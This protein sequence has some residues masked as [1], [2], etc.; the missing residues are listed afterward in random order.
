MVNSSILEKYR[1]RIIHPISDENPVGE[2][3]IDDADVDFIE[4]E[5]MKLGALNPRDIEWEKAEASAILLLEMRSKDLKVLTYLLQCLQ[6]DNSPER[7]AISIYVMSDFI[8]HYWKS[9]Y[10]VQDDSNVKGVSIRLK[11]FAQMLNRTEKAMERLNHG[12][13]SLLEI[14]QLTQALTA[15]E[16]NAATQCLGV[17]K[18]IYIQAQFQRR[19]A[20]KAETLKIHAGKKKE[21]Q[22]AFSSRSTSSSSSIA[23][24]VSNEKSR[25]QFLLKVV[26]FLSDFNGGKVQ[27]VRLRR[28][29]IWFAITSAPEQNEKGE[30]DL[31]PVCLDRI[32][33]YKEMLNQ[34]PDRVLWDKIEESVTLAPF[35]IDGHFLSYQTAIKLAKEDCALAILE[36][37][38]RF[39]LRMPDLH[40]CRF[41]GGLPFISEQTRDWLRGE[42]NISQYDSGAESWSETRERILNASKTQGLP[43]VLAMINTQLQATSMPREKFYWRLFSAE[44]MGN[45]R[46]DAIASQQYQTLLSQAQNTTLIDWEPSLIKR[47]KH[48][49]DAD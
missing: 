34:S 23:I 13:L 29:A 32:S 24:D 36:E 46:L 6:H 8:R 15:L 17:E 20:G 14:T 19:I 37:T 43:E 35:W 25:Y 10:P 7:L 33:D 30:T 41:N 9:A 12:L 2:R 42:T 1:A 22:S 4:S 38:Q 21:N 28:L 31:M 5:M 27:A 11:F 44:I 45:Y 47:L 3:L 16:S 48:L 26:D 18:V 39:V 40:Q 49:V